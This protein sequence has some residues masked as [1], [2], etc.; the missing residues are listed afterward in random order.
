MEGEDAMPK[1]HKRCQEPFLV[2]MAYS[3]IAVGTAV[4]SGPPH[5]SV[6]E[7]LPHTAPPLSRDGHDVNIATCRASGLAVSY[8]IRHGVRCNSKSHRSTLR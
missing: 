5:R 4:T 1:R 3:V 8:R 7:E 6:L 2:R